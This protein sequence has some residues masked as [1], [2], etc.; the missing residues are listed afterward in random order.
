MEL[1]KKTCISCQIE[2]YPCDFYDGH[3]ECKN[4]FK[5]RAKNRWHKMKSYINPLR[6]GKY[7]TI[8]E[9]RVDHHLRVD[10]GITYLYKLVLFD[11]QKGKCARCGIVF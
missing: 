6:R 1:N 7:F 11:L 10:Y 8:K 5:S 4:C 3:N 9:K 2:K